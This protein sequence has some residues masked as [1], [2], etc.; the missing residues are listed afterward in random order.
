MSHGK[1][2]FAIPTP[3][4]LV[5]A[6]CLCALFVRTVLIPS[7]PLLSN[8]VAY[9]SLAESLSTGDLAAHDYR[10]PGDTIYVQPLYSVL[11]FLGH[12][13]IHNWT[14]IGVVINMLAS[15][16][17]VVPVY[18]LARRLFSDRV[19]FYATLVTII[20]PALIINASRVFNEGIF[21]LLLT[22]TLAVVVYGR[23]RKRGLWLACMVGLTAG[24]ATLTREAGGLLFVLALAWIWS[25]APLRVR[26][27]RAA[28]YVCF[29]AVVLAP[30]VIALHGQTGAWALSG[31]QSEAIQTLQYARTQGLHN[32][33]GLTYADLS[34][35]ATAT[36]GVSAIAAHLAAVLMNSMYYALMLFIVQPLALLIVLAANRMLR[37]RRSATL[38]IFG[39]V[40]LYMLF[41]AFFMIERGSFALPQV[42]RYLVPILP[43]VSIG[44]A[45][46]AL[47]GIRRVHNYL[48]IH[49]RVLHGMAIVSII[50]MSAATSSSLFL[51][52]FAV[53]PDTHA[54]Q[55]VMRRW[56]DEHID[57]AAVMLVPTPA[58]GY[59]SGRPY[60]TIPYLIPEELHD[61]AEEHHISYIMIDATQYSDQLPYAEVFY[62][63]E[64]CPPIGGTLQYASS[65]LS[66]DLFPRIRIYAL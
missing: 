52:S 40:G 48:G 41:Y 28:V 43:L 35:V 34:P 54:E 64:E 46:G 49:R 30:Y 6:L 61:F 1:S 9:I 27:Q 62:C 39:F 16:L 60:Y 53:W 7:Q 55:I 18:L 12:F 47:E 38:I 44:I 63:Q 20:T 25:E 13:V 32:F 23:Q 36:T 58:D 31:Q 65:T 21:A 22:T 56:V 15:C 2:S 17:V 51:T 8:S 19:A 57:Q 26:W 11:L 14:V 29:C 37:L 3:W 59:S 66:D 5:V 50:G 42:S 33:Y 4:L 45:V 10:F 24:L